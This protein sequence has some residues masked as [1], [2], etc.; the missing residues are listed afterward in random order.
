MG[1]FDKIKKLINPP[2]LD[3]RASNPELMPKINTN[4]QKLPNNVNGLPNDVTVNP[5]TVSGYN[6]ARQYFPEANAPRLTKDNKG[7]VVA[8]KELITTPT[9]TPTVKPTLTPT[10]MPSSIRGKFNSSILEGKSGMEM[11]KGIIKKVNSNYTGVKKQEMVPMDFYD[12]AQ[13]YGSAL[14]IPKEVILAN[15][16][17]EHRNNKQWNEGIY[18]DNVWWNEE[19]QTGEESYGPGQI[20][21]R[22]FGPKAVELGRITTDHPL[23]ITPEEAKDPWKAADW[24]AKKFSRE[25]Q[26]YINKG[27]EPDW[28][29]IL[30]GYNSNETDRGKNVKNLIDTTDFVRSQ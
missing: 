9:V 15:S 2:L 5:K 8:E 30:Q 28:E 13:Q 27:L 11:D 12:A 18:P 29:A 6:F 19:K 1:L 7:S 16:R 25:A 23:Y 4:N 10:L 14:G 22:W 24:I 20:N 17:W 26:I 21:M 3:P